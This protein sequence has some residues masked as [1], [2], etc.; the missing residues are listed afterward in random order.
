MK[1]LSGKT[2]VVTGAGTGIG[3]GIAVKMA[4]AG[5]KVCVCYQNSE[6]GARSTAEKIASAGGRCII[7]KADLSDPDGAEALMHAAAEAFGGVDILVNNAAYQPNK[8]LEGYT[9][10]LFDRVFHTNFGGYLFCMRAALPYMKARGGGRIIN[11]SSIHAKRPAEF[12]PVYAMTKGAIRMLTREAA[13]E[14]GPF[15]ITVNAVEPGGVHLQNGKSGV[16][17]PWVEEHMSGIPYT[18]EGRREAPC[19]GGMPGD[20]AALTVF[21]ASDAARWMTG[22]GVRMDGGYILV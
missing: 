18:L 17:D 20:V 6:T 22:S 16:T 11:I 9:P 10:E 8:R 15:G 13:V 12:D 2:A 14:L 1:P 3:Q 21:I 7:V 4:E 19:G 5:A